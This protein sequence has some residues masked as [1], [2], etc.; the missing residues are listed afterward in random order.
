MA[1]LIDFGGEVNSN[2]VQ[3]LGTNSATFTMPGNI[4]LAVESV[5]ATIDNTAGGVATA[6]LTVRDQSGEVI[7]KK[8]LG[9]TIPAADT[10]TATWALRLAD[11]NG[12]SGTG[13]IKFDTDPQTGDWLL[14]TT[15]GSDPATGNSI[16]LIGPSVE[17]DAPDFFNVDARGGTGTIF[18][19]AGGLFHEK[20]DGHMLVTSNGSYTL[21]A[22][23]GDIEFGTDS[24]ILSGGEML[25]Q[26]DTNAVLAS[27]GSAVSVSPTKVV[28]IVPSGGTLEVQD[29]LHATKWR[30]TEGTTVLHGPTGGSIVFDL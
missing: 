12:A 11:S 3:G 23:S 5:L 30:W 15:T 22:D 1:R 24:Q 4:G 17:I 14:V 7:A 21:N 2:L 6:T 25:V 26:A 16:Y 28:V 10:G 13:F 27:G 20:A 19:E 18:L 29:H 8:R 9:E